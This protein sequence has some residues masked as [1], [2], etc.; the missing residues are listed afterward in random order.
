MDPFWCLNPSV[1]PTFLIQPNI[2]SEVMCII[3]KPEGEYLVSFV[4]FQRIYLIKCAVML[5]GSILWFLKFLLKIP[6]EQNLIVGWF[7]L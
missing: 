5:L 3:Y 2:G 6:G 1:T 4:F 7:S